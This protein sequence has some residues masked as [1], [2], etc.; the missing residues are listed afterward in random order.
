[1]YNSVQHAYD[2]FDY[3]ELPLRMTSGDPP[4]TLSGKFVSHHSGFMHC[5]HSMENFPCFT[6]VVTQAFV[7]AECVGCLVTVNASTVAVMQHHG[8][9][10]VR[11]SHP[12]Q[13]R[14]DQATV[15]CNAS[16]RQFTSLQSVHRHLCEINHIFDGGSACIQWHGKHHNQRCQF[17]VAGVAP[18]EDEG[19]ALPLTES[20]IEPSARTYASVVTS[21]RTLRTV[22]ASP[23]D[24]IK[25]SSDVTIR[26]VS[27][28]MSESSSSL[29]P[30]VMQQH[31]MC[32]IAEISTNLVQVGISLCCA[33]SVFG[34]R[35]SRDA[36]DKKLAV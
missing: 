8:K 3:A 19:T 33:T 22:T 21:V 32:L 28:A 7:N 2:F 9:Y 24:L 20:E 25:A 35:S 29:V 1:M 11:D 5:G 27:V 10:C 13:H 31:G 6:D 17:D 18:G 15:E 30:H 12:R 26:V 16:L 36:R 23:T 34:I 14:W 4:V